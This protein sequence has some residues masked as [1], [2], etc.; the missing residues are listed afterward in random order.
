[1][2]SVSQ[3]VSI[4]KLDEI[5]NKYNNV[6]H[7]TIKMKSADVKPSIYIDINKQNNKECLKSKIGDNVKNIPKYIKI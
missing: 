3:N 6:C 1:M 2:S 4:D 7:R 5:V